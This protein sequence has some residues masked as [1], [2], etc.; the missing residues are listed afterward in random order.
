MAKA[1]RK[2]N[3]CEKVIGTSLAPSALHAV[4]DMDAAPVVVVMVMH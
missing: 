4:A 1:A 2:W 3:N